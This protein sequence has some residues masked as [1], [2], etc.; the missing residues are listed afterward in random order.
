MNR[1]R[2]EPRG[3]TP[4]RP[5]RAWYRSATGTKHFFFTSAAVCSKAD[6]TNTEVFSY[7]AAQNLFSCIVRFST[8]PGAPARTSHT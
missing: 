3:R 7:T 2:A 6:S 8:P 1:F 4:E 5:D